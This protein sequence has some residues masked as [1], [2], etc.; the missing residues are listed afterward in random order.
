MI[1]IAE[2]TIDNREI[3]GNATHIDIPLPSRIRHIKGY[4]ANII[5]TEYTILNADIDI[6]DTSNSIN[7]I[8]YKCVPIGSISLCINNTNVIASNCPAYILSLLN[9]CSTYSRNI[10]KLQKKI[11]IASGSILRVCYEERLYNPFVDNNIDSELAKKIKLAHF[12]HLEK[13]PLLTN[14]YTLKIYIDYD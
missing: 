7:S 10:V 12:P 9:K 3:W 11:S 2:L 1:Y 14:S 8:Q 6:D 4:M 5:P 13:I